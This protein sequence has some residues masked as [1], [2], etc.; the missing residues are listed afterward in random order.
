MNR[1]RAPIDFSNLTAISD[2]ISYR[3]GH[4][5]LTLV[6]DL[7]RGRVIWGKEGKSSETLKA[8]FEEI[9]EEACSRI[10]HCAI[11]MS[12]A[13]IKA[14]QDALPRSPVAL[15]FRLAFVCRA[16]LAV[17][18]GRLEGGK[19]PIEI[20]IAMWR[21]M[22]CLAGGQCRDVALHIADLV[23]QSKGIQRRENS[24]EFLFRG[25]VDMLGGQE[26]GGR[27]CRRAVGL[28]NACAYPLLLDELE[29]RL[30]EVHEQP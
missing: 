5:Y 23:E 13:Y 19:E 22:I 30:E 25:L 4:R 24:A 17:P 14:V 26:S 11:D 15:G 16:H 27:S 21:S 9:G 3:K 1:R 28:A 29:R 20:R 2:E 8:F 10:K 18:P 6:V 7:E 12:A